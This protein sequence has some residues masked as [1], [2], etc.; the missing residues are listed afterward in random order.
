M[1]ALKTYFI[2]VVYTFCGIPEIILEGT[3]EDWKTLSQRAEALAQYDLEWWIEDLKPILKE[4]V[5]AS[6][7]NADSEFWESIYKRKPLGSGSSQITGWILEFFPY[8]RKEDKFEL[9][10]SPT[11]RPDKYI[12]S[13]VTSENIP[14]GLSIAEFT[15]DYFKK[16]FKMEF[17]AGFVGFH[18]DPK[19]LAIRPE[20]NWATCSYCSAIGLQDIILKC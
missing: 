12:V 16:P 5:K 19:S 4:F 15:W 10:K 20:I 2:Y 3:T 18:Q 11:W 13:P 1:D 6:E 9:R 17:A 8:V 14:S 7:G